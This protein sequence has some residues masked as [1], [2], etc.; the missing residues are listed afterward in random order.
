MASYIYL[1]TNTTN[2][3]CYIGKSNNP[4]LRW[5]QH[6]SVAKSNK[7]EYTL[8]KAM[9]KYGIA[10]FTF[11]VIKKCWSEVTALEIERVLIKLFDLRNRKLGYNN[12]DGGEGSFGFVVT[13]ETKEYF[14]AKYTGSKSVRAK[15]ATEQIIQ[16]LDEYSSGAIN[17]YE[18]SKKYGC[19]KTTMIRIISGKS[20]S[21]VQ[22]DRSKFKHIGESNRLVNLQRGEASGSAKLS[23]KDVKEIRR[24][25]ALGGCSYN[26]L[27][28]IYNVTKTNIYMIIKNKSRNTDKE[29]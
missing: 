7:S 25:Y 18:L 3:K 28:S 10:N 17:T 29:L 15:F 4:N 14:K 11:E 2:N 12:C 20:Y 26:D 23:T 19:G 27:A 21:D 22:Y 13:E 1:I 16:I 8:Y 24:L 6:K 9:R 5:S